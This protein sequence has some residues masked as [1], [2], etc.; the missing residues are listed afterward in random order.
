MCGGDAKRG[1]LTGL[2]RPTTLLTHIS[3]IKNILKIF[4]PLLFFL[5]LSDSGYRMGTATG[6]DDIVHVWCIY[7]QERRWGL[8]VVSVCI[9]RV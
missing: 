2:S 6:R 7:A 9:N 4:S 8:H 3:L 5:H 1:W